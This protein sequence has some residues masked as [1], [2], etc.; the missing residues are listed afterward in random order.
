MFHTMQLHLCWVIVQRHFMIQFFTFLPH[1]LH[2]S[3]PS[4]PLAVS[5]TYCS[6]FSPLN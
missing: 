6:T 4:G 1:C 2:V 3:S 5:K